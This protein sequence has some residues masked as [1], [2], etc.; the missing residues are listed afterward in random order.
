MNCS[1]AIRKLSY[2]TVELTP[3]LTRHLRVCADCRLLVRITTKKLVPR[4]PQ[5]AR[6]RRAGQM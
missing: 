5:L 6:V 4:V 3:A 1:E 2:E